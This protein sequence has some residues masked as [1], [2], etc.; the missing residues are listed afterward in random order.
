MWIHLVILGVT[1]GFSAAYNIDVAGWY[2]VSASYMADAQVGICVQALI[3]SCVL[4]LISLIM[5]QMN[6]YSLMLPLARLILEVSLFGVSVV[7]LGALYLS[8]VLV[9][10]AWLDLGV[11]A[12]APFFGVVAAACALYLFDFNYPYKQKIL[13][14]LILTAFS[15]AFVFV[16]VM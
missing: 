14:Y 15:L 16:R 10:N 5:A 6:A 11:A 2:E 7:S 9:K 12:I 8:W 13:G 3:G 1:L 4:I